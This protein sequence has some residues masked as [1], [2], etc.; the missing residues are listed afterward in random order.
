MFV[1]NN[2]VGI[3]Y[4]YSWHKIK[5]HTNK[6]QLTVSLNCKD[7]GKPDHQFSSVIL[8]EMLEICFAEICVN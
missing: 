3:I 7:V 4:Y 2:D 8:T 1:R 5:A 6:H